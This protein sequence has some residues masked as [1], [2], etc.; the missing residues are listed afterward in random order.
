MPD[1]FN[2]DPYGPSVVEL[3]ENL[4]AASGQTHVPTLAIQQSAILQARLVSDV[5]S[6]TT[7]LEATIRAL[8]ASNSRLQSTMKRLTILGVIVAVLGLPL[9]A[10]QVYFAW[11]V[12]SSQPASPVAA[13]GAKVEAPKSA[14]R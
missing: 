12:A 5:T 8:D 14:A 6:A 1:M 7:G 13:P 3:I 4:A 2:R 11:P 10:L 9:S